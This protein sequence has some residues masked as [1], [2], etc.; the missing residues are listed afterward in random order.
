[1][2]VH[3]QIS[4]PTADFIDSLDLP[5]SGGQLPLFAFHQTNGASK[6]GSLSARH[7]SG[8]N[9]TFAW[10]RFNPASMAYDIPVQTDSDVPASGIRDLESGGYQ[11]QVTGTGVDTLMEAWVWLDRL[12]AEVAK[13][14][15]G[16]LPTSQ[17]TCDILY[18]IAE[19]SPDTVIY[20]DPLHP[21]PLPLPLEYRFL[22]T[23]DNPDLNIPNADLI[24][25]P[26]ITYAPPYRDTWYILT[27]TDSLGM[28]EVD[29]VFYESIQ[30]KAEFSM[31]YLNKF[32][33]EFDSTMNSDWKAPDFENWESSEGSTDATLT[34]QFVNESENGEE[35][36]WVFLDTLGGIKETAVT[37]SLEERPEFTYENADKYY[38]PSL[39]SISAGGCEDSVKIE[40]GV[41]LEPYALEIP[42]VFSPN[43][44]GN[45]DIWYFK[46][47]SIK[48]CKITVVDRTGKVVYKEDIQDIYSWRGWDGTVRDS[49]RRAP[50]GQY[51]FV[52]DAMTYDGNHLKDP[53]IW[54]QMKIFGGPGRNNTGGTANPGNGEEPQ[55]KGL[56]TGW[57]YLYRN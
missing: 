12:E 44:D 35:F 10:N 13:N 8:G 47:Q 26:N 48:T 31:K 55:V 21:D 2:S 4:S 22:W 51:Y 54:S 28:V 33:G 34:V 38:Y 23:S 15:E 36:H 11:V 46:H 32:S 3:G 16:N 20:Y 39:L 42:N 1:M 7:P 37:Y 5:V 49:D 40:E 57:L 17:R 19:V 27:V 25:S 53:S 9:F 24:L 50:T 43:D 45:N 52:I 6:P 41:Y 29:S 14:N 56:Y 18:L 30:T